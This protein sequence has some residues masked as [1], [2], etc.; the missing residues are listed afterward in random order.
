MRTHALLLA[1]LVAGPA[2]ALDASAP[3]IGSI[4]PEEI[5]SGLFMERPSVS[6]DSKCQPHMVCDAG[7]H[8]PFMKFHRVNDQWSGGVF[9]TGGRG[10]RYDASR[11]YIGQ[12]EVDSRDRAWISCKFGVKEYGA[13]YGQG[14]WLFRN[15]ATDPTPPEQFFRFV[16][17]YKGMGMVTTD[18]KYPDQG[19]VIGTF[20]NYAILYNNGQTLSTGSLKAGAGGEKVR[21]RIASYAPR[22]GADPGKTY[23]DGIW[24]TA[25]NGCSVESSR[26]QNSARYKSGLGPVEWAAYASYPSQG[27]DFSHPG[28]GIDL[29][30]RQACY[31]ASVFNGRLCFNIWDG[32]RFL[33]PSANLPVLDFNATYEVRHGPAFAPAPDGGTF[34]FWTAGGRIKTAYLSPTGTATPAL[35]IAAGRSPAATTDREGNL[36]LVYSANGIRYRKLL[37]SALYPLAPAGRV[38]DTRSPVFTWSALPTEAYTLALSRDG[39]LLQTVVAATNTWTPAADLA[40]GLYAWA[41]KEGD[42]LIDK[43]WSRPLSFSIPPAIPVP[44]EPGSRLEEDKAAAAGFTWSCA[45]SCVNKFKV[46]LYKDADLL[47]SRS[48]AEAPLTWPE[49]LAAGVYSWRVKAFRSLTNYTVT[50]EWSPLKGFQVK[51]PGPC[52]ITD[53]GSLETFAPGPLSI[54]CS[55]TVAEGAGSYTLTLLHNGQ[56]LAS[57]PGVTETNYTFNFKGQPGYLTLL[58]EPLNDSGRGTPSPGRTFVVSRTMSPSADET[59]LPGGAGL[60]SWTRSKRADRYLFKLARYNDSTKKYAVVSQAWVTASKRN[61]MSVQVAY[62]FGTG[63]YRWVITDYAGTSPGFTSTAYFKIADSE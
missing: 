9:A 32:T 49:P 60:F 5:V 40:P 19:V 45:D 30:N 55:W 13:M 56:P 52:L 35:D 37:L 10:G 63:S 8:T 51:V 21:A 12:I 18:A 50:S 14:I 38:T 6:T 24:H 29:V 53:P 20:G 15:V 61:P 16:C 36:H 2:L 7:G 54:P 22:F 59:L 1:L 44:G 48:V 41:V 43:P 47:G 57:V 39:E 23:A 28:L 4:G 42:E 3:V 33:F 46:E 62:A 25:F 31:L 11:L 26:Y 27:S 58:V 17:V 34:I